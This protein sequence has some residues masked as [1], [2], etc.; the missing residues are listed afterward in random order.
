MTGGGTRFANE[1]G[2]TSAKN[3]GVMSQASK[4]AQSSP[5]LANDDYDLHW[6]EEVQI[7]TGEIETAKTQQVLSC[8][9]MLLV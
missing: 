1:K 2:L 5:S 7:Q 3:C 4:C 6:I 9:E 8:M